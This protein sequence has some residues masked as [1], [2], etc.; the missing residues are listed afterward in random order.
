MLKW[1]LANLVATC[2]GLSLSTAEIAVH[3]ELCTVH[4]KPSAVAGDTFGAQ[5]VTHS[6]SLLSNS[7]LDTVADMLHGNILLTFS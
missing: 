5:S 2:K 3:T 6:P 7:T 4:A 1:T